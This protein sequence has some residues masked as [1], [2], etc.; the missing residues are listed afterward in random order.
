MNLRQPLFVSMLTSL[1]ASAA[2]SF[3]EDSPARYARFAVDGRIVYGV[4]EDQTVRE[5][6]GD[7]FGAWTPT[8]RVHD[9]D[10]VQL[11]V[12]TAAGKVIALAGN[13]RDHLG[14]RPAPEFPEPFFKVPSS[15]L[16]L[17]LLSRLVGQAPDDDLSTGIGAGESL[18]LLRPMPES[19]CSPPPYP[20]TLCWRVLGSPNTGRTGMLTLCDEFSCRIPTKIL[21]SYHAEHVRLATQVRMRICTCTR[22]ATS[23]AFDEHLPLVTVGDSSRASCG[24]RTGFPVGIP[25]FASL[26]ALWS[27]PTFVPISVPRR[28][29]CTLCMAARIVLRWLRSSAPICA[30]RCRCEREERERTNTCMHPSTCILS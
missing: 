2:I 30:S 7:L 28:S 11:L 22:R 17:L 24:N 4:V 18:Y 9:L 12:P 25:F 13:Y 14:D 5:I 29:C 1:V 27:C 20:S 21:T 8:D 23:F 10:D 15:L 26:E 6:D 19:A 3:A 16:E